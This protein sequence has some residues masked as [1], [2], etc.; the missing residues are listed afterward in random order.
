[1]HPVK[2]QPGICI[3]CIYRLADPS[4]SALQSIISFCNW[5]A[6]SLIAVLR[7]VVRKAW[8]ILTCVESLLH[9]LHSGMTKY[10]LRVI[11]IHHLTHCVYGVKKGSE[12][13]FAI[14]HKDMGPSS[15]E[16]RRRSS[17]IRLTKDL[18]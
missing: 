9:I 13:E 11:P 16:F 17:G 6:D 7:S 18:D 12:H 2:S 14:F 5:L 1:M 8:G 4:Q 3:V 10:R 15:L